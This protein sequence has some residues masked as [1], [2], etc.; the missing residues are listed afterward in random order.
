MTGLPTLSSMRAWGVEHLTDAAD[1]WT[2][3]ADRWENTFVQVWQ[4]SRG[5]PWDGHAAD[6]LH[7]RTYA[8]KTMVVRK[9]D[10]LREA[11]TIARRGASDIDAAKRRVMYAVEDAHNAGFIVGEDLSVTDTRSSRDAAERAVRQSQAQVFAAD[12]RQRAASLAGLDQEVGGNITAAAGDVGTTTFT[13][14]PITYDGKEA[15]IRLVGNGFK[16]ADPKQPPNP[17]HIPTTEER[18]RGLL[19][20][21]AEG[22]V[23][24]GALGI[25]EGGV[26]VVPGMIIG[27]GMGGIEW[28]IEETQK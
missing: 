28:F 14:K 16:Q 7:E 18:E 9:A 6:A 21:V 22:A 2:A 25:P 17:P 20:R 19:S 24:G 23:I 8:D 12:I 13:E 27:G 26:G 1:Q 3:T 10:Q 4:Q 11:A 5:L 15:K